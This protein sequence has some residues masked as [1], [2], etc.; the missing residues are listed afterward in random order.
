MEGAARSQIPGDGPHRAVGPPEQ[1]RGR[2]YRE[3]EGEVPV[4]QRVATEEQPVEATTDTQ[5]V[6]E[7]SQVSVAT[8]AIPVTIEIHA[9]RTLQPR[10]SQTTGVATATSRA[11]AAPAPARS[12][13]NGIGVWEPPFTKNPTGNSSAAAARNPYPTRAKARA[14]EIGEASTRGAER[15][16]SLRRRKDHIRRK[17]E[18]APKTIPTRSVIPPR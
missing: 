12:A 5:R 2:R 11:I 4:N 1:D 16:P 3:S 13:A 18:V 6:F 9:A 17:N 14:T 10:P 7:A 8:A 15:Q